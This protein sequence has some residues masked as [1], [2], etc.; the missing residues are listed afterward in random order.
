MHGLSEDK[1]YPRLSSRAPEIVN[2]DDADDNATNDTASVE[3]ESS[4]EISRRSSDLAPTRMTE[5][6]EDEDSPS[7]V[8]VRRRKPLLNTAVDCGIGSVVKRRHD[9]A[10]MTPP[11]SSRTRIVVKRQRSNTNTRSGIS[12]NYSLTREQIQQIPH[13]PK[14]AK[15]NTKPVNGQKK[16]K[17]GKK[18]GKKGAKRLQRQAAA[19]QRKQQAQQEYLEAQSPA[20][21]ED[22]GVD[23]GPLIR[24]REGIVVDWVDNAYTNLI[25]DPASNMVIDSSDTLHDPELDKTQ[26][27]RA[28]RRKNGITL[29]NCLDE[30]EREEVLS[31]NDTWYCP[32]CKQHQRA[33][34]KFDLWKTPDIL[35]VHLKRFS[36]SGWRRDKLEVLVDFPIEGLDLTERVLHKEDGKTEMYDLIGVDCHWGGLGG[37]HYTAHAKN[38]IDNQWYS[39]NGKYMPQHQ[40]R[41]PTVT[42]PD[43]QTPRYPR[44]PPTELWTRPHTCCSTVVDRMCPWAVL[45]LRKSLMPWIALP[46]TRKARRGKGGVSTRAPPPLGRRAHTGSKTKKPLACAK[47]ELMVVE[48]MDLVPTL[49]R[50][51]E[52]S[53]TRLSL[54]TTR[55]LAGA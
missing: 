11:Q 54:T 20:E 31:E 41:G 15:V 2:S 10:F 24:L 37:G 8:K 44:L 29:E 6:T 49:V 51:M 28:K 19:A 38:F 21:T 45:V 53:S 34:K 35:V 47:P 22:S 55:T 30:F 50:A 16:M 39:Y 3:D 7:P 36:S 17:P 48:P 23:G 18:Y 25:G 26:Q 46:L 4:D 1:E 32:R 13:R 12:N 5:E 40:G 43:E 14:P 33:S 27:L 52:P 9:R 42:N